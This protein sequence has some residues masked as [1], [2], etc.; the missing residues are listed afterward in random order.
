MK[1]DTDAILPACEHAVSWLEERGREEEARAWRT[2]GES[3]ARTMHESKEERDSLRKSDMFEPHGLPRTALQTLA[4]QFQ[5][6]PRVEKAW[7][8]RK[9]VKHFQE[10]PLYVLGIEPGGGWSTADSNRE[11]VGQ[12]SQALDLPG[13]CFIVNLGN[14]DNAQLAE[15]LRSVAGPAFYTRA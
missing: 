1:G 8:V 15:R 11:L 10:R 12:L 3:W 9:S 6:Y 7:L 5:G 13:E 4:A 14:S 2:R